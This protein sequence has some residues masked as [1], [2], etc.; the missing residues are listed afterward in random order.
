MEKQIDFRN[1]G[2]EV[3]KGTLHIPGKPGGAGVVVGHCFTCSR[4]IR[5]LRDLCARLAE[6]GLLALRFDFSG[7]GQS[8]GIFSESTYTKQIDEMAAAVRFLEGEGARRLGLAGHSMGA[9]IAVLS[10]DRIDEI[11]AVCA[12]AGRSSGLG[13]RHFLSGEQRRELDETGRVT[14]ESRGRSLELTETFFSDAGGY[15]IA[16]V[17]REYEK[18]LLVVHGEADK[19]IP[20][21]EAHFAE[22]LNPGS[23]ELFIVPGA[24]HMFLDEGHRRRVADRVSGWFRDRLGRPADRG[25]GSQRGPE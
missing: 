3:L 7:N 11:G 24:D 17:I 20:V 16:G 8:Q 18:P 23:T 10:G 1:P 2:G 19:I 13:A 5:L 6:S 21:E 9:A 14:F 25:G 4:N 15:D 12:V 22:N